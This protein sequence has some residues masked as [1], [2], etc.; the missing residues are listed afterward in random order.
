MGTTGVSRYRIAS[1]FPNAMS[2]NH[3][4]ASDVCIYHSLPLTRP[5]LRCSRHS[6]KASHKAPTVATE[7]IPDLINRLSLCGN[8]DIHDMN[9]VH[10]TEKSTTTPI[11]N[12]I[13]KGSK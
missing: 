3:P 4:K 12:G 6:L 8:A 5:I 11:M 9:F 7:N 13:M 2:R 10:I 1:S